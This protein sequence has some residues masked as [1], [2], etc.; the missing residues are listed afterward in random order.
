MIPSPQGSDRRLALDRIKIQKTVA[1]YQ[2]VPSWEM[3]LTRSCLHCKHLYFLHKVTLVSR[4]LQQH[5]F[6]I[7]SETGAD[8]VFQ[9]TVLLPTLDVETPLRAP[10]GAPPLPLR[11]RKLQ[12]CSWSI[13][14]LAYL[15]GNN[16]WPSARCTAGAAGEP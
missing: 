9:A 12:S 2:K 6:T 4:R 11:M 5:H 3:S 7:Q 8:S 16:S 13:R 14:G 1:V 15:L 10:L